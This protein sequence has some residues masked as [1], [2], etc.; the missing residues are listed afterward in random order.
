MARIHAV[1]VTVAVGGAGPTVE[2]TPNVMG[3]P[4]AML[5]AVNRALRSGKPIEPMRFGQANRC[6]HPVPHVNAAAEEAA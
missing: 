5:L 3:R 1:A 2:T 6:F 4:E